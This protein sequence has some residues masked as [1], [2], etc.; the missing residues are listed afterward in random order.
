MTALRAR[1]L[2]WSPILAVVLAAPEA[3]AAPAPG[4][5]PTAAPAPAPAPGTPAP[6]PA[7]G[8]PAP[9]PTAGTPAPAPAPGT[10]PA[11]APGTP[12]PA[13]DPLLT[14]PP[15]GAPAEPTDPPPVAEPAEPAPPPEP[16]LPPLRT[17]PPPETPPTVGPTPPQPEPAPRHRIIY[18]NALVARFNPLGLEDRF[19][20]MYR[21]RLSARTGKLWDD[22][23]FGVGITPT[24]SP[25]ITR[26]GPTIQLVPLAIL[27]LRASYYFIG[28]YGSQGFK[29]HPFDS[30]NDQYGPDTIKGR[31]DAKQGISTFGGQ[32]ELSVL[33]Q[34][35]FGPIALRDELIFFHNNIKLP[36]TNDVFYDLRHDILAPGKGWFLS[37]D[38]DLLY[39]NAKIRLNAGVRGTYYHIFYP[40]EVYEPGDVTGTNQNDGARVGPLISYSFKDRPE[41]RFT[42]PTLF[43]AAQWWVKHRYRTGQEVSQGLP[44]MILGFSFTGELWSKK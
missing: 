6:A 15:D 32:A 28:Y 26:F 18:S 8:T 31:A 30:P 1:L 10:A 27:Q 3:L 9:A 44:L 35:K 14:A 21:R 22:T 40:G 17:E 11:P 33:F 39:T 23:Y 34:V 42:K 5:A 20:L 7:P 43:F 13:G 38:T 41:K 4:P 2:C 19:S 36:G 24:F 37:N 25:S 16:A 12:A 29:A